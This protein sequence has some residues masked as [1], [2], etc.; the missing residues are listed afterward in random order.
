MWGFL[1]GI[2]LVIILYPTVEEWRQRRRDKKHL[3]DMRNHFASNHHWDAARGDDAKLWRPS[4]HLSMAGM[5]HEI[6]VP[7]GWYK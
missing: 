2:Y 3:A 1:T 4:F 5:N 7:T 6:V